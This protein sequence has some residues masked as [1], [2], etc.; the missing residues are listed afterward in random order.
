MKYLIFLVVFIIVYS[1]IQILFMGKS[2]DL[3]VIAIS[4]LAGI[5]CMVLIYAIKK[6]RENVA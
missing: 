4:T 6:I 3:S 1:A 5:I 2:F